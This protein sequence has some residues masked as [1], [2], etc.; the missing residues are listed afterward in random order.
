MIFYSQISSPIKSIWTNY[1]IEQRNYL[2]IVLNNETIKELT[3]HN[4][5]E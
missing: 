4:N 5:D 1:N 2:N 3:C